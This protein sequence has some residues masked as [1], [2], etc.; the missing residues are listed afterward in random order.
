MNV[1]RTWRTLKKR[2]GMLKVLLLCFLNFF[3]QFYFTL[4]AKNNEVSTQNV[5]RKKQIDANLVTFD[6]KNT[7][8]KDVLRAIATSKGINI[9]TEPDVKGKITIHLENVPLEVGLRTLLEANGFTYKKENNIYRVFKSKESKL[10]TITYSNGLLSLDIRGADVRDVLIEIARQSGT[11]IVA[12]NTVKGKVNIRLD[13]V[14]FETA[15]QTFLNANGFS[16]TKA[17]GIYRVSSLKKGRPLTLNVSEG[18]LSIDVKDADLGEIIRQIATQSGLNL[19]IF[20]VVR[21]PI[22]VRFDG[23]L[24]DEAL[25]L[26]FSGT[27]YTYKRKGNILMVGEAS[28]TGPAAEVLSTQKL[29][30]LKYLKADEI[31]PLLPPTIP[32]SNIKII[33]DQNAIVAIGSDTQIEEI[34]EYISTID[35]AP[36][37]VMIE[38]LVVEFTKSRGV[39]FGISGYYQ[40]QRV[41][42]QLASA[43]GELTADFNLKAVGM[44]PEDFSL[45]LQA[46][47]QKGLARIRASPKVATI[48]GKDATINVGWVGYYEVTSGTKENPI[49]SLQSIQAGIVLKIRPWIHAT[50]EITVEVYQEVSGA[51][52]GAQGLPEITKRAVSTTIRVHNGETIV[53]GGLI[54]S[55]EQKSAQRIPLLGDI[56]IL[57]W[58]FGR[59]STSNRRSELVT[60]I[61]PHILP[62]KESTSSVLDTE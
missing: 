4:E 15:L 31:L 5:K 36:R 40:S 2:D 53:I 55:E 52:E 19:I 10:Y 6:F 44:L 56:P 9:V 59:T 18:L 37:Q 43:T 11:N 3:Y 30:Q 35:H 60:Y 25:K 33:R 21:E 41:Q 58:L 51:V 29:I 12:D 50:D 23:V 16:V 57:G 28:L 61:T 22:N 47:V 42:T 45:S 48:N 1:R 27:K 46:L 39:D 34:E 54:Q 13:K 7:D 14:P 49:T 17:G 38:V 62:L 32:A 26:I 8:I 20:G 24:L